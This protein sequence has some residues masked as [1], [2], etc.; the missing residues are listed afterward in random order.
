MSNY[1][2]TTNFAAKDSLPSGS[3][4]KII[5]GTE[6]DTEYN[7]IATAISTKLDAA[8]G[9]V[10]NLTGS[11]VN[12]SIVGLTASSGTLSNLSFASGTISNLLT[13]LTVADGGTGASTAAAARSNLLPS[14][15]S[16]AGKAL[17][18]NSS[19]TDVE[20]TSSV[21]IQTFSSSG[22]WT[23]P[24]GATVVKVQLWGGGGG[25]GSV[26]G[27]FSVAAGNGGSGGGGG[28]YNERLYRAA[29]LPATVAVAV[30]AGGTSN[31]GSRS[32][33]GGTSSFGSGTAS[34]EMFAYGGEGG[35]GGYQDTTT[36]RGGFGGGQLSDSGLTYANAAPEQK[37]GATLSYGGFGGGEGATVNQLAHAG[38]GGGGGAPASYASLGAQ[39]AG[40]SSTLGGGGGG[41]G[42]YYAGGGSWTG[43]TSGG[44]GGGG[45][46]R[47]GAGGAG[48][49]G[50]TNAGSGSAGG[51][52]AG[53]GGGAS[54]V[55]F[56]F[57]WNP[58]GT[59]GDGRVVITTW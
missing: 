13:D 16:N 37:N 58:G 2:K 15:T 40:G 32:N 12:L 39:I 7:N 34:I 29:D 3:A 54:C 27:D 6:H 43:N 51:V 41:A 20:W 21:N 19:G 30:G 56:S 9:S 36:Q 11:A 17:Y 31:N 49:N 8:S 4:G 22:T 5:K 23:K 46:T 33:S 47:Y 50:G 24:S 55:N 52:P 28:G 38:W 45:V 59:G 35:I 14:Y 53:G 18:V 10:T 48:G 57:S 42:A 44:N 1:T 25:G 26:L